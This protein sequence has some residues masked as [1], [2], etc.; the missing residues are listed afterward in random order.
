MV[1]KYIDI[2]SHILPGVDD[3]AQTMAQS[4]EMLKTAAMQGIN[5]IVLT[6]H[7]KA[8]RHSISAASLKER[9]KQLQVEARN[10]NIPITLYPGM[11]IF[12]RDGVSQMLE[13]GELATM[14]DSRYVLIEFDPMEQFSYI[15]SAI[16]ELTSCNYTP[17]LAHV[18]RYSC[19]LTKPDNIR[20]VIENGGL[21]Q[22]NASSCTGDMGFKGNQFIKKLIKDHLIHFIAT[23][24]HDNDRRAPN[25]AGC[26]R[27]LEKKT[28]ASYMKRLFFGNAA[29]MIQNESLT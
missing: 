6:P 4:L 29:L 10:H 1:M 11:E 17:I 25:F 9:T 8:H 19:F 2:H 22:V 26:V 20:Y 23:D 28:D 18:E 5:G 24:T 16:Y 12:Y 13:D 3:G 14:A 15:R 27:Y 21:I 7:N